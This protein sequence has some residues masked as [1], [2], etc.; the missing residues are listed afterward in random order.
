MTE[1]VSKNYEDFDTWSAEDAV[2][3]MYDGQVEALAALRPALVDIASAVTK[4]AATLGE[5]GRLVYVGAG[6]S[7]RLAVQDGAEL[8][9]TFNWP[10]ERTVFCIAGGLEALTVSVEGAEDSAKDGTAVIVTN[11]VGA[12]DVVIAVAASGRTPYTLAALREAKQRGALTIGIANNAGTL[13]LQEADVGILAETG[14]EIVAG[15]TRMKAGTAQKVVLNMISTAIMAR[16]GRVYGGYMVDMVASNK[17]LADRAVRMV[18]EIADCDAGTAREAL[19]LAD[20]HIKTAVL[21]CKGLSA[22]E[23][24]NLL[25]ECGGNLRTALET[26]PKAAGES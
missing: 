25:E 17:K 21:I 12:G 16:L 2:S 7:G 8:K 14:S 6:T 10:Q 19:A 3:A 13:I 20:D 5:Q 15:S 9:P 23:C 4:A 22:Q 18:S 26:M 24:R 11:E 1:D